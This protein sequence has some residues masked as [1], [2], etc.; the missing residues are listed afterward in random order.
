IVI[1]AQDPYFGW[2]LNVENKNKTYEE[3]LA[4]YITIARKY[5]HSR[6][7][8]TNLSSNLQN[9]KSRGDVRKIFDILSSKYKGSMW[10]VRIVNYLSEEFQN[11]LLPTSRILQKEEIIRDFTK[12][13]LV[14]F[15]ASWCKPCLEEIPLLKQ[16]YKN[17]HE[18]VIF[19][20][21]SLDNEHGI[22]QFKEIIK[23]YEIPWRSLYAFGDLEKVK[24]QYLAD[25]IPL[26]LFIA[27][28]GTYQ[29]IDVRKID[30]EKKI[31]SAIGLT[32]IQQ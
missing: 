19:T 1:R 26:N 16:I 5:P 27:P 2:F 31:Y 4:S 21:V 23:Q 8:I 25:V 24:S 13:N 20:Y 12:Y 22:K 15:T 29:R 7:L 3:Y 11:M 30:D 9:F 28:D 14:I 17:V 10:G 18:K 32:N 6:F